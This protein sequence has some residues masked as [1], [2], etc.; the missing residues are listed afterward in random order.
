MKHCLYIIYILFGAGLMSASFPAWGKGKKLPQAVPIRIT[1]RG[2]EVEEDD[3]V[4]LRLHFVFDDIR[5]PSSRSLILEPQLQG[6]RSP[7]GLA[8]CD[9]ERPAPCPL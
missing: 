2:A 1:F 7:A 4:S 6:G 9:G 8:G 5:V 3:S